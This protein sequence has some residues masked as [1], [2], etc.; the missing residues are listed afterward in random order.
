MSK[1][2]MKYNPAFLTNA[3]LI[4]SF[5]VRHEDL[6]LILQVIRE[7]TTDSNQHVLVTGPRG[8]GK[9]MLVLRTAAEIRRDNELDGR[10]YPLVFAEESYQVTTPGEFWLEAIFHVAEQCGDPQWKQ[11]FDELSAEPDEIR[12]RERALAHLM[13]FADA[14]GKRILLIVENLNML[15]GEQISHNDAWVLRHTL[16]NEPRIM[17]LA[18]A[19]QHFSDI[20]NS[21][22][23][24]FEMFKPHE[25]HPLDEDDCRVL[26]TKIT[27]REPTRG[28]IRP[29]QILTG[30]NPR[31]LTIIAQFGAN[32]SLRELMRDLMQLVDDHTEYFKSHLDRLPTVERKVYLTLAELWDPVTA[33]EVADAARLNVN[34][35]SAL[36]KRL[37]NRGA[38][39]ADD[40]AGRKKYYRVAERMYN[41]YYLMRRRG[42]PSS[43]VKAVVNF[44]VSFYQ[45]KELVMATR[46]IAEEACQLASDRRTDHYLAF[47]GIRQHTAACVLAVSGKGDEALSA[48]RVY[49]EDTTTVEKNLQ[50]ATE[51]AVVLAATGQGDEVL[52]IIDASPRAEILESL[53]VGL[54]LFLGQDVRVAP[55]ILEVGKDVAKIVAE[56]CEKM[57][58][59]RESAN[60]TKV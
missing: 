34:K 24:L 47:Q 51:L 40:E 41:I 17:L 56:R 19:T 13:D 35:T 33:R 28:N 18:T 38:V 37:R 27:G 20:E 9:T 10:W 49:Y 12:L 21:G 6:N 4:N 55:E 48:A 32:L 36:L 15:L 11:T 29:V 25:L 31:L 1:R 14:Q 23:A 50:D 26:W 60:R 43:R 57:K 53:I 58:T 54:R 44:M 8:I 59:E 39:I 30:G 5:V 22:K 2:P 16:Q 46:R 52:K 3:E 45:P 7:N 42:T